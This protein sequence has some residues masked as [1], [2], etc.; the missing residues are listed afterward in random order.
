MLFEWPAV[1]ILKRRSLGL[2]NAARERNLVQAKTLT[3]PELRA[4]ERT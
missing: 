2:Q 4:S 1:A 3:V